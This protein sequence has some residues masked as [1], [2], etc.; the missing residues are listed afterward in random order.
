MTEEEKIYFYS[1]NQ[2]IL[3]SLKRTKCAKPFFSGDYVPPTPQQIQSL[4]AAM[5]WTQQQVAMITGVSWTKKGSSTVRKWKTEEG[6]DMRVIPYA[7]WRQMLEC[8][9]VVNTKEILKWLNK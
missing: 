2:K 5:G 1:K 3:E 9:G 6:P 4:I 7:A 8:A